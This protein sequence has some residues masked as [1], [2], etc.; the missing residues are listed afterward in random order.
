MFQSYYQVVDGLCRHCKL[1]LLYYLKL[2]MIT[3]DCQ[4]LLGI[5]VKKELYID[6]LKFAEN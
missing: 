6:V 2:S 5:N 3:T 1:Q 4:K